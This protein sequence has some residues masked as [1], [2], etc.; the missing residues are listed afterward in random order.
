MRVLATFAFSFSA[1]IF[2]A[3]YCLPF[4]WTPYLSLVLLVIGLLLFFTKQRWTRLFVLMLLGA[5]VGLGWFYVHDLRTLV[6][7][8]M[9]EGS[10]RRFEATVLEYPSVYERYCRVT[11]RIEN[12]DLPHLN[13]LLYDGFLSTANMEPGDRVE[14]EA[15]LS[16]AT[17]RYNE[18]TDDYTAKDIYLKLNAVSITEVIIPASRFDRLTLRIQHALIRHIEQIFPGESTAFMKALLLGEKSDLYDRE[19]N[20]LHLSRAGNMHAL[21]VSGVQYLLLGFYRIARKPVNWALF[22]HRT[23]RCTPKLRFT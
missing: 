12:E 17:K 10:Q 3:V 9:L 15:R 23:R 21:A 8:R 7:A 2:A 13:A 22:G 14:F 6:P 16:A 4:G 20:Y 5:A 19:E 18:Q 11:V 1:A